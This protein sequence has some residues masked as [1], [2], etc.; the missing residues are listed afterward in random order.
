MKG[1]ARHSARLRSLHGI[2]ESHK[3][4]PFR[5]KQV[6]ERIYRGHIPRYSELSTLPKELRED[7][8]AKMKDEVL[9]IKEAERSLSSQATKFLFALHDNQKIESVHMTFEKGNTSLCISS[10]VGCAMACSFCRF[11]SLK[12]VYFCRLIFVILPCKA[13]APWALSDT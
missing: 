7:I 2:M 13:P 1:A 4:P 5:L 9:S 6:A 11:A 3:Q 12:S 10:Q 8:V